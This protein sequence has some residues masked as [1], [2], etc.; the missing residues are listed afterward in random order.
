MNDM[1]DES[2]PG[3][4]E[5]QIA[6]AKALCEVIVHTLEENPGGEV[7]FIIDTADEARDITASLPALL[8]EDFEIQGSDEGIGIQHKPSGRKMSFAWY[9][10]GSMGIQRRPV[11]GAFSGK[12]QGAEP[13]PAP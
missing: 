11:P 7:P 10:L 9:S 5:D 6:A 12:G 4:E 2:D 3:S 1:N 8:G 13:N